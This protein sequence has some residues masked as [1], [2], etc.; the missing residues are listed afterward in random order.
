MA[1]RNRLARRVHKSRNRHGGV[2]TQRPREGCKEQHLKRRNQLAVVALCGEG[3]AGFGAAHL[4]VS[5]HRLR[6]ESAAPA[7][8][9]I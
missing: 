5:K 9:S 7:S 6:N 2:A 3:G 8:P 1:V 4:I